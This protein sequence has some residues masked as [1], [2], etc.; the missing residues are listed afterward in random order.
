MEYDADKGGSR[1]ATESGE[2][3]ACKQT[4]GHC[5]VPAHWPENPQLA[6]W[7]SNQRHRRTR[8]SPLQKR[9]LNRL[10]FDW[11]PAETLWKTHLRELTHFK[12]CHGHCN[13]PARWSENPALATWVSELRRRGKGRIP[14]RWRRRLNVLEFEWAPARA[15]WWE[16]LGIANSEFASV[17]WAT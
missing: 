13:V 9:L 10:G 17:E 1:E 16:T 8:L 7:V 14:A 12:R 11:H 6:L 15:Q 3:R 4:Y 2:L 5:N